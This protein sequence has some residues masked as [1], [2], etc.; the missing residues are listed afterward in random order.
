MAPVPIA[1]Q[2]ISQTRC[3]PDANSEQKTKRKQ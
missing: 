3:L 2:P 1:V